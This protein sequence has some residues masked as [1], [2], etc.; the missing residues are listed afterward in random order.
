MDYILIKGI[1]RSLQI[2]TDRENLNVFP[3][4]KDATAVAGI[5]EVIVESANSATLL[6]SS[7]DDGEIQMEFFNCFVDAKKLAGR[8]Y[9]V[10]FVDGDEIAFVA[11]KTGDV[12]RV[13]SA[14]DESKRLIWTLPHQTR[15]NVAQRNSDFLGSFI[16]ATV[17]AISFF[18]IVFF[19]LARSGIDT[20]KLVRD[21]VIISFVSVL[22]VN[23]LVR[24]KFYKFSHQATKIFRVLGFIN[25][26][27]VDL[28]KDHKNADVQYRAAKSEKKISHPAWQF[29]FDVAKKL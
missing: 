21:T 27:Y 13:H 9:K 28:P 4:I 15:G 19:V 18:V 23:A 25:P 11:E 1:V 14:C 2:R 7:R 17:A 22:L 26:E 6:S 29:R 12:Y 20:W 16:C 5:V 24:W 10:G 3:K 8:F